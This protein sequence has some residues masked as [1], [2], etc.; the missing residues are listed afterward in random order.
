MSEIFIY[1]PDDEDMV[2]MGYGAL[3]ASACKFRE[4]KNGTSGIQATVPMWEDNTAWTRIVTGAKVRVAV[5]ARVMPAIDM[6]DPDNPL[7]VTT[8][9][10]YRI[11]A[12]ASDDERTLYRKSDA[13]GKIRRLKAGR[14]VVVLKAS[15]DDMYK[16]STSAGKGYMY[17]SALEYEIKDTISGGNTGIESV[18][19]PAQTEFQIFRI[20]TV[21]RRMTE[22]VFEADHIFYDLADN[23]TYYT[24]GVKTAGAT[25]KGLLNNCKAEH[26]FDFVTDTADTRSVID[27]D[28]ISPVRALLDPDTGVAAR[29]D[30]ELVRN[31]YDFA[32]LRGA[33]A[34]RGATIEYGKNM[35]SIDISTDAADVITHIVPVGRTKKGKKLYLNTGNQAVVSPKAGD[36]PVQKWV[37]IDYSDQGCAVTDEVT[38]AQVR[39]EMTR[40]ANR[41]FSENHVDDPI[42][43]IKVKHLDIGDTA[44]H[45]EY[46]GLDRMHLYDIVNIRHPAHG[47]N[48]DAEVVEITYDCLAERVLEIRLSNIV[49]GGKYRVVPSWQVPTLRGD[50]LIVG[51]VPPGRLE[52]GAVNDDDLA[53]NSVTARHITAEAIETEKLKAGAVTA[54]KI[55]AGAIDTDKLS[56]GAVTAEKIEAGTITAQQLKAGLITADSGLIAVGAIQT[57]QIADGSITSA[58]IVELSADVIKSGTLQTDRLLLV[59][60]GGVVYEINALSS[61]LSQTEL[62]DEKYRSYIN[63]TVIVANS[64]T[65]AQIAAGTITA[66]EIAANAITAAKINVADLFAS[67]ATISA[68]N[69]M[70]IRSNTYL[71]LYVGDRIDGISVG[72]RNLWLRTREYDPTKYDGWTSGGAPYTAID[73]F[74]VQ[75]IAGA[76]RDVSQNVAVDPGAEYTLSAWIKWEDAANTGALYLYHSGGS[77]AVTSQ[78]GAQDYARVSATYVETGSTS[79][80]RF[81]CSTDAPYLIYG[82][83]LEKGNKATDWSP[84]PEDPVSELQAESV[85]EINKNRVKISTPEFDVDIPT[86]EGMDVQVNEKGFSAPVI[87]SPTVAKAK[88]GGVYTVGAGGDYA[89]LADAFGDINDCVISDD[90]WLRMINSADAGGVLRGV[91]GAGHVLIAPAN[92]ASFTDTAAW[93]VQNDVAVNLL[94][95]KMGVSLSTSSAGTWKWAFLEIGYVG[96]LGLRGK[97]L[98]LSADMYANKSA[99]GQVMQMV[100]RLNET[101]LSYID[102]PNISDV[103]TSATGAKTFVIPA[104]AGFWDKLDV[105]FKLSD[106]TSVAADVVSFY[107]N[108]RL[109]PGSAVSAE[110][111]GKC[112]ATIGRM[113]V[114]GCTA[115]V[116]LQELIFPN[117]LEA[118]QSAVTVSKCTF[119]GTQGFYIY[120]GSGYMDHCYGSCSDSAVYAGG[121]G[122]ISI[123]GS[124][125]SGWKGGLLETSEMDAGDP[126]TGGTPDPEVSKT[127]TAKAT[128]T[129]TYDGV[130]GWWSSD[131]ALRQGYVSANGRLRGGAW[132]DLSALPGGA[133]ITK[134][135]L[136]LRRVEGYGKGSAVDVRIYGTTADAKSGDPAASGKISSSY[137]SGSMEPGKTRTFDVTSLK[138]YTGFVLYAADTAVLSGKSYSTNYARFTGTGGGDDTIP[139]LTATYTA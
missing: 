95:S 94:G 75:R 26:G 53:V 31:N 28:G 118:R 16:V 86:T 32:M 83:K 43:D 76:W 137:V 126:P 119:T 106:G 36:Y 96:P 56:A 93:T 84:A 68:I 10:V 101:A 44:D 88:P 124:A 66:N 63:G 2:G 61:G 22:I 125:P 139:M 74:G 69:A 4:A 30:L 12:L 97:T 107:Y 100:V 29:W 48:V 102:R 72:G 89:C 42:Y 50:K 110:A 3:R 34:N 46:H 51:T 82:L 129:G 73:G 136:R 92:L 24:K 120:G 128:S 127:I 55:A 121:G 1:A 105:V 57:A 21:S 85:V 23:L 49:R 58:K 71:Q 113:R 33:G 80:C 64:I 62:S 9:E 132:F 6:D 109:E 122:A 134:L 52:P 17:K 117:V 38:A 90:L 115:Q 91:S 114:E 99:P 98:T 41:E 108:I 60:E 87:V 35:L 5:P 39:A 79:S 19:E 131:A 27:Y 112:M 59:G 116:A 70:D 135:T 103:T 123:Y 8:V 65:A 7:P 47:L 15:G 130:N 20:T 40:L 138:A 133:T 25:I 111:G 54:E 14:K 18:L 81:E 78:V 13:T 45:A 104:D 67:E 37:E 11:K 77:I